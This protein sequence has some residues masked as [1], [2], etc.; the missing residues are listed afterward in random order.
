[1]LMI[2]SFVPTRRDSGAEGKMPVCPTNVHLAESEIRD[3][4]FYSKQ[5]N[6]KSKS[7]KKAERNE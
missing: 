5:S 1:L 3:L 6:H 2:C 7:G 4:K